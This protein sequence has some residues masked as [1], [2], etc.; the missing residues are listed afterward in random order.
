MT[1]PATSTDQPDRTAP[2][3]LEAVLTDTPSLFPAVRLTSLDTDAVMLARRDRSIEVLLDNGFARHVDAGDTAVLIT[4]PAREAHLL[5]RA[6]RTT[7]ARAVTA[8]RNLNQATERHTSVLAA[9]RT[10]AIGKHR[11]GDICRQGLDTFLKAF[12]L[13]PYDPRIRVTFTITGSYLVAAAN[14]REA[15]QD[16]HGYLKADLSSLDNVVDDS[17][18]I[19]VRIDD[20][21]LLD[22][23]SGD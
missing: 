19:T 12:D 9:I 14:T 4:E 16:A 6:L 7:E 18:D 11:D 15:E 2:R 13:P 21:D 3:S 1:Q 22:A 10:Y 5:R 17:E 20:V 8:E 23:A